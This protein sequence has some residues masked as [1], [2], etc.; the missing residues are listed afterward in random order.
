MNDATSGA[1]ARGLGYRAECTLV[2]EWAKV[3]R[4]FKPSPAAVARRR[5]PPA[6]ARPLSIARDRTAHAHDLPLVRHRTLAVPV[7]A[8]GAGLAAGAPPNAEPWHAWSNFEFLDDE[9]RVNEVDTLVLSPQG[10]FLIEIKSR[11]GVLTGDAHTWTWSGDGRRFTDDN[12]LILTNRKAKRLASLLRRQPSLKKA[13]VRVPWVQPLVFLSSTG[14]DCRLD[15]AAR[16]HIYGRG[17]PDARETGD[18]YRP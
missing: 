8:R 16:A 17:T 14:T 9:G 7:G 10:L 5:L 15:P 3:R 4:S 2:G 1:A 12:P 13:R 6:R 18:S 11:P